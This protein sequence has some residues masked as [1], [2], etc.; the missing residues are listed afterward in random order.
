MA[1]THG[2]DEQAEQIK[3]SLDENVID[4]VKFEFLFV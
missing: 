3:E 1:A 2:L 4:I